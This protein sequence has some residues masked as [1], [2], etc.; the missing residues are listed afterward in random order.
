M[1]YQLNFVKQNNEFLEYVLFS[2]FIAPFKGVTKLGGTRPGIELYITSECNQKCEYCYLVRYGDELYPKEIRDEKQI[3]KNLEIFLSFFLKNNLS[4]P[5]LDIFSGEILGTK[6][7]DKVLDILLKYAKKGLDIPLIIIPTNCSFMLVDKKV[8]KM[9]FYIDEFNKCGVKISLS[10]SIDG[11]IVD[12]QCRSFNDNTLNEKRNQAF[13]DRLIEFITKNNGGFHPMLSAHFIDKWI[14]NFD[15]WNNTLKKHNKSI[16]HVMML[17]VR[18]N[19]WNTENIISFLKFLNHCCN[20]YFKHYELENYVEKILLMEDERYGFYRP[21]RLSIFYKNTPSC[22]IS[23]LMCVRLGDLAIAPCHRLSYD[24]FLYG[25]F[26]VKDNEIIGIES[27]N[28]QLANKILLGS[29]KTTLQCD[30]CDFSEF[31]MKGCLG[32]HYENNKDPFI[33]CDSVCELIKAKTCFLIEKYRSSGILQI[34]KE[35]NVKNILENINKIMNTKE[36]YKWKTIAESI[37]HLEN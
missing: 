31:C 15:W 9:Q 29:C 32:C 37:A 26:K 19:E 16:D 25:K 2:R 1:S 27:Q 5:E 21:E 30:K 34:L 18:N 6:L 24:K 4:S 35:K 14:E 11:L 28:I 20:I 3:I 8:E 17:E 12:N 7:G 13:Y 23:D 33:V 10:A 36:Y 22:T